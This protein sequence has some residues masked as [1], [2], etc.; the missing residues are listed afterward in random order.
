[1]IT[2]LKYNSTFNLDFLRNNTVKILGPAQHEENNIPN[3]ELD[4]CMQ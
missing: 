2:W 3:Y 1:M 4:V